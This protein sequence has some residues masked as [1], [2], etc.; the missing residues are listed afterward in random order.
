MQNKIDVTHGFNEKQPLSH[1]I[2]F[3][4]FDSRRFGL[5]LH[6]RTG[7]TPNEKE[8]VTSI[9]YMQG[10]VDMSNLIG[11]RIYENREITYTFYRFGAKRHG[12]ARDFQTTITNLLM[13]GFDQE[14]IDSFEPDFT[15]RGKCREVVVT[16]DYDKNR[17]RIEISFDLY[18]FKVANHTEGDDLFDPFNFDMDAFHDG[19]SFTMTTQPRTIQ[20]YNASQL[21]LRPTVTVNGAVE[22]TRVGRNPLRLESGTN[23]TYR[24]FRLEQGMNT[25]TLRSVSGTVTL[26][27]DW[28]KERI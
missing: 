3:G 26:S 23:R 2:T 11:H 13:V 14:L 22:L 19:L 9:P 24:D 1:G 6:A 25:L 8:V 18:P 7:D 12:T 10:V 5:H 17:L 21:V 27:F 4:N 15:Y 20:L 28:R 16:D